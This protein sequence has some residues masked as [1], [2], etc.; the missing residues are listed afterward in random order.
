[1]RSV[2]QFERLALGEPQCLVRIDATR[3][4][5][6]SIHTLRCHH[7]EKFADRLHAHFENFPTFTLHQR[8]FAQLAQAKINATIRTTA[9]HVFDGITPSDQVLELLPREA[10]HPV[11]GDVLPEESGATLPITVTA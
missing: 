10:V 6:A 1:L 2:D 8:C 3:Y 11:Q 7:S 9:T 4:E 5:N